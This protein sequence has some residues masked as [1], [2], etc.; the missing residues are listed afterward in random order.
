MKKKRIL[1]TEAVALL[2]LLGLDRAVKLWSENHLQGHGSVVLWKGVFQFTYARNV[3]AAFSILENQQWFF[4]L[5]ASIISLVL[6]WGLVRIVRSEHFD[7]DELPDRMILWLA[8]PVLA[9]ALGNL[10]DRIIYGYVID[11][12][13]FVLINYPIFNVADSY[14]VIAVLLFGIMIFFK[15][16]FWERLE[17]LVGRPK[18]KSP[19]GSDE[20]I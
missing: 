8:P 17:L 11:T 9:G 15:K 10:I 6:C 12:F 20:N 7:L 13:D 3:G 2:L 19:D 14:I 5:S 4:I 18:E 16:G 1:I